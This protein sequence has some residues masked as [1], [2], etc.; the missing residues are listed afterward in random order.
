MPIFVAKE[1]AGASRVI[2]LLGRAYLTQA[3][4]RLRSVVRGEMFFDHCR[5]ILPPEFGPDVEFRQCIR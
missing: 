1:G 4:K 5:A 3:P 2:P